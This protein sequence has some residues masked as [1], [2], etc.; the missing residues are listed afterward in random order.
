MTHYKSQSKQVQ[1]ISPHE[2][3]CVQVPSPKRKNIGKALCEK[4][5][6]K[7]KNLA[8]KG[9]SPQSREM[10]WVLIAFYFVSID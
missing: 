1:N 9:E 7:N 2:S 6:A 4:K 8:R 3:G 5:E 10:P